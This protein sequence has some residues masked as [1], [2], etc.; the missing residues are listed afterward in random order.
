MVGNSNSPDGL[1]PEKEQE[2][3]RKN[4]IIRNLVPFVI[5]QTGTFLFVKIE[6]WL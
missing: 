2:R 4:H 6:V 5:E 1:T 3:Q